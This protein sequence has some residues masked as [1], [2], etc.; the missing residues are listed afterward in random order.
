MRV[1][2]PRVKNYHLIRELAIEAERLRYN[3]ARDLARALH[4]EGHSYRA[5]GD[6]M[7]ISYQ[8]IGQLLDPKCRPK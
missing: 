6:I 8:R 7:G 5:I 4:E 2:D 3:A 1:K